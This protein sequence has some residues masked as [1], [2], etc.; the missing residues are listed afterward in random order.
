M[1]GVVFDT[2]CR[3]PWHGLYAAGEDTGGVHGANR[4]GGNGVANSTVFGALAGDSMA[5]G[6]PPVGE[7]LPDPDRHVLAAAV[8][9]ALAPRGRKPGDG[10]ALRAEL[11]R[12]MWEDVG[13]LRN[14]A[15]LSRAAASLAAL[16]AA[17]EESGVA[18]T[19]RRYDVAWTDRLNLGNLVLVSRA[20]VTAALL[21][22]DSRGAHFRTDHPETSDLASSRYTMVRLMGSDFAAT[23]EPVRFTLVRPGQSLLAAPAQVRSEA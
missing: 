7:R 22:T 12:V 3:T 1:G 2:A 17:L 23:T 10:A 11:A 6:L 4:L 5:E 14:A 20:I 15:S 9:R 8:G 19:D 21:R 13:V 16:A 18:D